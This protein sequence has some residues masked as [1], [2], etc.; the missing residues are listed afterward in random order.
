VAEQRRD[1]G[2][3]RHRR[4]QR[5]AAD[6]A[7]AGRGHGRRGDDDVRLQRDATRDRHDRDGP[8]V[9]ARLRRAGARGRHHQHRHH[10]R[11]RDAIPLHPRPERRD[12]GRRAAAA[13]R[14]DLRPGRP[15]AGPLRARRGGRHD[16]LH[17][18]PAARRDQ[19]R[20]R[21]QRARPRHHDPLRLH[22]CRSH[23]L[24]GTRR[25]R[26]AAHAGDEPARGRVQP[27]ERPGRADHDL[28]VR[29]A[30]L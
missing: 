10:A 2:P 9:A 15:G 14:H 18:R 30:H 25:Q 23:R 4:L 16:H 12:R 22:L 29:P 1:A 6:R 19:P 27:P 5:H 11:R 20:R 26:R 24:P 3:A 21:Q 8:P 7:H 17:L 28:P 13:A